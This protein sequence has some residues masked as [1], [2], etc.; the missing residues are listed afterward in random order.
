MN[1]FNLS[2]PKS[3]KPYKFKGCLIWILILFNCHFTI[4][5]GDKVGFFHLFWFLRQ[6]LFMQPQLSWN[7]LCESGWPHI[8]IYVYV[9]VYTHTHTHTHT[10]TVA[11]FRHP[12]KGHQ[13]LLQMVVS[14]HMVAGN[15]TQDLWKRSRCS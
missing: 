4:K 3:S 12:R 6:G 5:N 1:N 10:H 13:I 15:S 8:H 2:R 14:H 11:V 9:Y 7:F